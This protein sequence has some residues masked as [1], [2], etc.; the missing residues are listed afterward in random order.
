M[1]QLTD[2]SAELREQIL[3]G[4]MGKEDSELFAEDLMYFA[5]RAV[6]EHK[7]LLK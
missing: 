7:S 3:G 1:E 4:T 6:L 2:N 5:R